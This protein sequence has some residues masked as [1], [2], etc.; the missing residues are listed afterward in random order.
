[1]SITA[2]KWYVQQIDD[3]GTRPSKERVWNQTFNGGLS[4]LQDELW[5]IYVKRLEYVLEHAAKIF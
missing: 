3:D 5:S 2:Y 1:M 4:L